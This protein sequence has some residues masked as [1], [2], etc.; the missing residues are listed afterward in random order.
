MKDTAQSS[1]PVRSLL[2]KPWHHT[3]I[4]A[5]LEANWPANRKDWFPT[6]WA[7]WPA[8]GTW[9]S[10]FAVDCLTRRSSWRLRRSLCALRRSAVPSNAFCHHI[11]ELCP[12]WGDEGW[13][14]WCVGTVRTTPSASCYFSARC[15]FGFQERR[16]RVTACLSLGRL[17]L[18][19]SDKRHAILWRCAA[20]EASLLAPSKAS[21][22]RRIEILILTVCKIYIQYQKRFWDRINQTQR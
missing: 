5:A 22:K 15:T 11:L 17:H 16:S 6:S 14:T 8:R 3:S 4:P 10:A 20:G 2:L 19:L 21:L 13:P 12:W 7:C 9:G 18:P 1:S